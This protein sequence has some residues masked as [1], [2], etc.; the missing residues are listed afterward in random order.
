MGAEE[1]AFGEY[2][3]SS[4]DDIMLTTVIASDYV[5]YNKLHWTSHLK[6]DT[7]EKLFSGM[8]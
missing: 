5:L 3:T 4:K 7:V 6:I 8:H 1:F 2:T